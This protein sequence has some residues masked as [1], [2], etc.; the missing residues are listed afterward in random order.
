MT[1][2][3]LLIK[4]VPVLIGDTV[5][6]TIEKGARSIAVPTV[7][8]L[9]PLKRP[10]SGFCRKVYILNKKLAVAWTGSRKQAEIVISV[11]KDRIRLEGVSERVLV[12]SLQSCVKSQLQLRLLGWIAEGQKHPR[13]FWWS[14]E[15]PDDVL[16]DEHDVEGTGERLFRSVF[17]DTR[18]S[19][20]GGGLSAHELAT[21]A[22][23]SGISRLLTVETT[24]G[25]PLQEGFGFCYDIAVWCGYRFKFVSSYTQL[26]IDVLFDAS[27]NFRRSAF[28][29]Q[30]LIYNSLGEA[31]AFA[32]VRYSPNK[33]DDQS[34]TLRNTVPFQI[35]TLWGASKVIRSVLPFHSEHF[36][37][38]FVHTSAFMPF[39]RGQNVA[40]FDKHLMSFKGSYDSF[41][42]I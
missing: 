39:L 42:I 33:N 29:P 3:N 34:H 5:L 14:V 8:N 4:E 15:C 7:E 40:C 30:F 1:V 16:F 27:K 12:D 25:L 13:P 19:R 38:G 9:P 11:L 31:A 28:R 10:I 26:N 35:P 6:T 18:V 23:L 17:F 36:R 37:H 24:Q 41:H 20:T 2:A 21:A 22:C 32:V